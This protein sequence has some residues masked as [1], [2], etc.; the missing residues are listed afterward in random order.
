MKHE[1]KTRFT[2]A[3][4]SRVQTSSSVGKGA[5]IRDEY[6]GL[7]RDDYGDRAPTPNQAWVRQLKTE[8]FYRDLLDS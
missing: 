1:I 8:S 5:L 7:C 4:S 6:E 3:R 2:Q